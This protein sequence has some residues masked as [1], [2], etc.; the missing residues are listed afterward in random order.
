MCMCKDDRKKQ[1]CEYLPRNV[2]ER[3]GARGEF[4]VL[5]S[6]AWWR[7]LHLTDTSRPPSPLPHPPSPLGDGGWF[8]RVSASLSPLLSLCSGRAPSGPVFLPQCRLSGRTYA[9]NRTHGSL[10]RSAAW[11]CCCF[12][13]PSSV[14]SQPTTCYIRM[15]SKHSVHKVP[16]AVVLA[17]H[18]HTRIHYN[19]T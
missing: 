7:S 6:Q 14:I 9:Q 11:F 15:N 17:T 4:P 18:I 19:C 12:V 16:F 10:A 2:T 8:C 1:M 13:C 5:V 3:K